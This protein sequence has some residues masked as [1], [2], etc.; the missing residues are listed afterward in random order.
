V[1]RCASSIKLIV[2]GYTYIYMRSKWSEDF[3]DE[4]L[5]SNNGA[6]ISVGVVKHPSDFHTSWIGFLYIYIY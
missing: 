1:K 5:L 4:S 2:A 3:L 6:N